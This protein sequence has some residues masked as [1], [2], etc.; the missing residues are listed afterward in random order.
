M[1]VA[2]SQCGYA[3]SHK[4]SFLLADMTGRVAAI[5]GSTMFLVVALN[6]VA[7]VAIFRFAGGGG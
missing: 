1:E 3:P 4:E 6:F 2:A 5:V 7:G